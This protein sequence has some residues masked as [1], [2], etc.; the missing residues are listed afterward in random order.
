M[1]VT[2][3]DFESLDASLLYAERLPDGSLPDIGFLKVKPGTAPYASSLGY[4]FSTTSTGIPI[5]RATPVSDGPEADW[6]T[7]QGVRVSRPTHGIYIHQ[8]RITVRR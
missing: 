2:T 4:Q 5:P 8:G 7:L 6:Y 3:D 1:R